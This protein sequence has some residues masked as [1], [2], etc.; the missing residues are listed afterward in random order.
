MRKEMDFKGLRLRFSKPFQQLGCSFPFILLDSGQ[1][2]P[3]GCSNSG[4]LNSEKRI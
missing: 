3:V 1:Q 4:G 2:N